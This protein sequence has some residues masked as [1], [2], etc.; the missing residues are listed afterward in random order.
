[1]GKLK[2][3]AQ[4]RDPICALTGI[5]ERSALTTILGDAGLK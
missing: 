1:L 3:N 5:D 2:F 4:G